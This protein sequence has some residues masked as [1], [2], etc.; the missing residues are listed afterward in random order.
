MNA[1]ITSAT[2]QTAPTQ[3]L[4][5][6]SLNPDDTDVLVKPRQLHRPQLQLRRN[7]YSSNPNSSN[8]NNN[9]NVITL[10]S[11]QQKITHCSN[12]DSINIVSYN[13]N[14]SKTGSFNGDS[15]NGDTALTATAP[16]SLAPTSLAPT[17][18]A[19]RHVAQRRVAPMVTAPTSSATTPTKLQHPQSQRRQHQDR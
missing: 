8:D 10:I 14:I 6:D 4:Q 7:H 3:Q 2:T 17:P 13:T 12:G 1:N 5:A 15:S 18:T 16:T 9:A 19:Q 11:H